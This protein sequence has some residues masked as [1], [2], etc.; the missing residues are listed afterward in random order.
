[1]GCEQMMDRMTFIMYGDDLCRVRIYQE[2]DGVNIVEIDLHGLNKK[3]AA[4]IISNVILMYRFSFRLILIH[5]Y[6]HGTAL[7]EYI[8]NDFN[9]SRIKDKRCPMNNPGITYLT[10][11]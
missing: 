5:G 3:H 7:K 2:N 9:N 8:W 1:M 10:I 11:A 6:N 4:K